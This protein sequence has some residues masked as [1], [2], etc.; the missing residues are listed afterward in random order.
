MSQLKKAALITTKWDAKEKE[1]WFL[2]AFEPSK[3]YIGAFAVKGKVSNT[4][5]WRY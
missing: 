3:N 1:K 4:V 2:K 5:F